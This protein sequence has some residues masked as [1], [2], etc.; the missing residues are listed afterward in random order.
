MRSLV[1]SS[2]AKRPIAGRMWMRSRYSS[3]P[4]PFG[5]LGVGQVAVADELAE[6]WDGP[7]LLAAGLRIGTKQSLGLW[8]TDPA[9]GPAQ[10]T[11]C[12]RGQF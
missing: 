12:Q 6:G 5:R 8:R 11:A 7:Q 9:D 1:I 3:A 10:A 2:S 4:A